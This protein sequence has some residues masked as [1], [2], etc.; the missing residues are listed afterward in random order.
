VSTCVCLCPPENEPCGDICCPEGQTCVNGQCCDNVCGNTC[1]TEGQ[2]CVNGQCCTCSGIYGTDAGIEWGEWQ[3]AYPRPDFPDDPKCAR[4][5]CRLL[6]DG[7]TTYCDPDADLLLE[8][9]DE[10]C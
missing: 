4:S 8:F 7:C 3:D 1:C 2:T 6:C 9:S 10:G 5:G